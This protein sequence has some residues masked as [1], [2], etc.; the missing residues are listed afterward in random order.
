MERPFSVF[1]SAANFCYCMTVYILVDLL[2]LEEFA[3]SIY[4]N[5]VDK[6][7]GIFGLASWN[8]LSIREKPTPFVLQISPIL[9]KAVLTMEK[10]S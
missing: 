4:M 7:K 2:L 8:A 5:E 1:V 6:R 3:Y 9:L 10:G